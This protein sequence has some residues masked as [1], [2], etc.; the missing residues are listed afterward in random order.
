M[1]S[2]F[3]Y[4]SAELVI[5]KLNRFYLFRIYSIDLSVQQENISCF[6]NFS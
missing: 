5:L 4:E 2:S 3:R 6:I 1:K